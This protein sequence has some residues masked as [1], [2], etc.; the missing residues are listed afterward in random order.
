[1]DQLPVVQQFTF[2]TYSHHTTWHHTV[3][4]TRKKED[5]NLA[6]HAIPHGQ[7]VCSF[8]WCSVVVLTATDICCYRKRKRNKKKSGPTNKHNTIHHHPQDG[9]K[10]VS[11]AHFN[12]RVHVNNNAIPHG[13][14][15]VLLMVAVWCCIPPIFFCFQKKK[16][17][18]T[19]DHNIHKTGKK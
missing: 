4:K 3:S 16:S 8:D 18:P 9:Q 15:L 13:Q 12:L 10:K 1:M 17:G 19:K 2:T 6:K 14:C 11:F 5:L 7:F